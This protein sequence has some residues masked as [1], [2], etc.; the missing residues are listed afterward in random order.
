MTSVVVA[1]TGPSG[2]WADTAGVAR[3]HRH[4]RPAPDGEF[5][6][7]SVTKLFT[8][9]LVLQLTGEGRLSLDRP[10]QRYLPGLLPPRYPIVRV[11]QLLDHTSGLPVSHVDDANLDP[12]WF[13]H[14]RFRGWS[15]RAIV[16]DATKRRM[17]FAPGTAQSYN[18][19]NYF[20]AGML[21]RAV[22]G[23]SFAHELRSRILRPL[24][25]R[26]TY[27]PVHGDPT[28]RGPH[29]HGYLRAGGRLHDVSEQN[30][31]A[32]AEGGMVSTT[33]DLARLR[34]AV[35]T[36]TLLRPAQQRELYRLPA[37]PYVGGPGH[38][39]LAPEANR[40]CFSVMFEA[41][42]LPNGV[43]IWGRAGPS[44]ATRLRSSRPGT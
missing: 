34:R 24:G 32:W 30:P 22:T 23:H 38:C 42:Q 26:H 29:A 25:L 19:T 7:G 9:A 39:Q 43:T 36:G 27:L 37:V 31:Y 8:S 13:V 14:H 17:E 1:V 33:H 20:V 35:A 18:G 12:A 21:V 10:V 2:H 41:T 16:A 44:P 3:L 11:R 40:A 5:R 15:P 4:R 6:I 28:L